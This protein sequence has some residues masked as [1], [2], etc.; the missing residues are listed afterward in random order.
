MR[1]RVG[2]TFYSFLLHKLLCI[3]LLSFVPGKSSSCDLGG[4]SSPRWA[5]RRRGNCH[6]TALEPP[7]SRLPN[8]EKSDIVGDMGGSKL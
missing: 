4:G 6:R 1:V 8:R 2:L 7:L 5:R 3:F